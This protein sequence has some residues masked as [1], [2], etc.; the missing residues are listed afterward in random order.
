MEIRLA[1][2]QEIAGSNPAVLTAKKNDKV[3]DE[4]YS[5]ERRGTAPRVFREHEAAGSTPA[6]PI[7]HH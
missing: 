6:V 1:G 3:M 5:P 7:G 2:G 4:R